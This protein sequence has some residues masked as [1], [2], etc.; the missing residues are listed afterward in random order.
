MKMN[1]LLVSAEASPYGKVGGLGDIVH[2]LANE[3]NV[4]G[5][6]AR[7]AVP[8]YRGAL[9]KVDTKEIIHT[10][11]IPLGTYS[12][13]AH[14]WRAV[15]KNQKAYLIQDDHDFY[16]GRNE[17]YGY[18]DDYERFIFFARAVLEMLISPE[19]SEKENK[20]FP[21]IIQ[22][23]DWVGG[24][25][26][27][28]FSGYQ[29]KD[30]R[31]DK[32]NFVF[33]IH[34]IRAV[35]LFG[36]RA[37]R[38][39]EQE[40]FGIF[41]EIN[42]TSERINFLGRGILLADK[43]IV[44]NPEYG[45]GNPLP[46]SAVGLEDVLGKYLE[47]N[48]IVGIRNAIDY[49]EFDPSNPLDV[50]SP[51]QENSLANRIK[52][53]IALQK[54]LG[55]EQDPD[56]PLIGMVSRLIPA[57]G[58][59][60]FPELKNHLLSF[61]NLQFVILADPGVDYFREMFDEWEQTPREK[62]GQIHPWAKIYYGYDEKLAHWIYAAS[63]IL[64]IPSKEE[65]SGIQQFIAMRYGAIP[66][67]HHT[68]V[69]KKSIVPYSDSVLRSAVPEGAGIGFAF[70]NFTSDGLL[71]T[72]KGAIDLYTNKRQDWVDIQ[73]INL[74]QD[75]SWYKPAKQFFQLYSSLE[76]GPNRSISGEKLARDKDAELL[77]T[78]LEI[79]SLPGMAKRDSRV[80]LKQAA[81]L[82]RDVVECDAVYV[83]VLGNDVHA[84][85][86]DIL[87]KDLELVSKSLARSDNGDN[88][89][90][91]DAFMSKFLNGSAISAW[92]QAPDLNISIAPSPI[93]DLDKSI[94]APANRWENGRSVLITAHSRVLGRIDVLFRNNLANPDDIWV[95]K[96]LTKIALAF[97]SRLE[98]IRIAQ[99]A[100]QMQDANE[101]LLRINS[102]PEAVQ[103]ILQQAKEFSFADSAW[104]YLHPQLDAIEPFPEVE[105]RAC[106]HIAK[107]AMETRVPRYIS[108]WTAAMGGKRDLIAF[109]S[110]MAM[111]L[112][113]AE[114]KGET[115]VIGVL[116]IAKEK[117]AGFSHDVES[118]LTKWSTQAAVALQTAYSRKEIQQQ[119]EYRDKQRVEQLRKLASSLVGGGDLGSLLKL[120]VK[121]TAEVLEAQAAS[122]YLL[123]SANLLEIRA[124]YGYHDPL[125]GQAVYEINEGI[126]GWIVAENT[127]L[128]ANTLDELHCHP[129]WKGKYTVQNQVYSREP[130]AFLGIP[131]TIV[132]PI[133]SQKQ[134]I[135]VLKLEDRKLDTP[136]EAIEFSDE[137]VR[138]GEMMANVIA[139][140]VY[141]TQVSDAQ[142]KAY[143]NNLGELS[144]A[145]A[146]GREM[147]ELVTQVVDTMARVLHAEASSLY[148]IDEVSGNLVIKAATGYQ[149]PLEEKHVT[150]MLGEGITGWIA[151][152]GKPFRAGS[153]AELM[154]HPNWKGKQDPNQDN[155]Q[156]NSY[157]GLPLKVVDRA[158][159]RDKVIGVLKVEDIVPSEKHPEAFFT[160][161]DVLL[162]TMMA[163]VIATV[164]YNTQVGDTQ[165]QIF[166]DNLGELSQAL[167]G[168]KEM[169][170]LV[171]Q[172]V[173]TMARVLHAE[174][175]SLYLIE[176]ASGKL[177]IKA[178]TGYQQPLVEKHVTYTLGEGITGWIADKGEAFRASS[179]AELTK[180][181]NW[182]GKQDPNQ[183]NRQP[184]S[185]LGLPLKVVDRATGKA[186][187][188]GVLKVEDIVPSEKHSEAF[189]TDQDVL[190]VTMMANVI[191]TVV[192]N[193]QVGDA[194]LQTFSNNL[195][196]LSQALTGGREMGELVTKVVDTMA[197]VLHAEASSLYLIDEASGMLVIQ[198]AT[199]YQK[200]LVEKHV[201]YTLGEGITG[202]IAEKGEAFRASSKAELTKH[203]NWK[204]KQDPNQDNRQPNS[205]LGL[206][207]KVVDRATKQDK[208]IG[209]LKVE[210]VVP[211]EKHPEAFFTD[212]DVLLVT[213]M[214]NVI[215]AVINNT[216][217]G[218]ARV[219]DV[220]RQIG[221]LSR[222]ENAAP[223]LLRK[224]AQT[225]NTGLLD[226][227]AIAIANCLDREPGLV[228]AEVQAL[229]EADANLAIYDR[230]VGWAKNQ[231]VRWEF[232]LFRNVLISSPASFTNWNQ[233][234]VAA[235]PW[236]R[237]RRNASQPNSF[238]TE[239]KQLVDKIATATHLE[240][241]DFG[242][243]ASES[244]FGNVL[245]TEKLFGKDVNRIPILFH[246]Q[247]TFASDDLERMLHF[248]D[249]GLERP[250]KIVIL[251]L[252]DTKLPDDH[253]RQIQNRMRNHAMDVVVVTIADLLQVLGSPSPADALRSMVLRQMTTTSPFITSGPVPDAMFFGRERELREITQYVGADRSIIVI[254]GRRIGKTSILARLYRVRLP[255][256]G[257]RAIYLDCSTI[258]SYEQFLSTPIREWRP[259]APKN[260]CR[261]MGDLLSA[262]PTDKP[263]VLL[264]DEADK[265]VPFERKSKWRLFNRLRELTNAGQMKIILS[266]ESAL[267]EAMSDDS[268]PLF[269]LFNELLLGRLELND[270][271]ELVTRPFRQLE[272]DLVDKDAIVRQI[273]NITSGHPNVVQR[274]CRR[275]INHIN[276]TRSAGI[277]QITPKDVEIIIENPDFQRDDFLSTYFASATALE[278]I[279]ILFMA[280]D[281]SICTLETV[282]QALAQQ[283]V[284]A[285]AIETDKALRRLVDLRSI[286]K[287]EPS[288]YI[289]AVDAFPRVVAGRMVSNEML[290]ILKE[291]YV[292][293]QLLE[294]Q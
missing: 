289:F 61:R 169:S 87:P 205:Y 130:R 240:I 27:A 275:L 199:G 237:I 125:L 88:N 279:I 243:D 86:S 175:S 113:I 211:S 266:G 32:T 235:E 134:V 33:A 224:F 23:Y 154:K 9:N 3:L 238:G 140:V 227:L 215:A 136:Q 92:Y 119:R 77:Q 272:I 52:N 245:D 277:R 97:G 201:T 260:T 13:Y 174:A 47:Q 49:G 79:D 37:L 137:D 58:F 34:N 200:P 194:Q 135:G 71:E 78:L 181:P 222:P 187:V 1:I 217:Q 145:L 96:A 207:L 55:F 147:G 69:L 72:L 152:K 14:I 133:S 236:L 100:D 142:L 60:I 204:G 273:Y 91:D 259:D 286:L 4:Q 186:R 67:V 51:F 126:T 219:G 85:S 82:V 150:Y 285:T 17:I 278:Q 28:W 192:Y 231:Q 38:V 294:K 290:R 153:K 267:R 120:V 19:F 163:N 218:E 115:N 254:G 2:G 170:A 191:A 255:E 94:H 99:K 89:E 129:A 132:N 155:R 250:Y 252:W 29:K 291:K 189:F 40:E 251:V 282:E 176:E 263:L 16:F 110:I 103:V 241:I 247:K 56:I 161:Q 244:W 105:T 148:L 221:I 22:G 118:V 213:M 54:E 48:R 167:A 179:K 59:E 7:I 70:E 190:L 15:D 117:P 45:P 90:P 249:R 156:P 269:N 281:S 149:K 66:L 242:V 206:P 109:R 124:A 151:D 162:V 41:K 107:A 73:R 21:D 116:I 195:G 293:E 62:T 108:D 106:L 8:C 288:G 173:D 234:M 123:N 225:D 262:P 83:W 265:L 64:M 202:W 284:M 230:I 228:D 220:L 63:D 208:V 76:K 168:G 24:I 53:K 271:D 112:M 75:F 80:M 184:N 248:A 95:D 210:D 25:I 276:E 165:L 209:V 239:V 26:P 111:P 268:S 20:W 160:D 50:N 232:S 185:Y 157:L 159:K 183:D 98:S 188:I 74:R 203:P 198:A 166:S 264:L 256:L 141:N 104:L 102:L 283:E 36:Q 122:L 144:Q 172:V 287:R 214:A 128:R 131:L 178:A 46:Q 139:T 197:R 253:I 6:D 43:V 35:R 274:L 138:L 257:F 11:D 31:F 182:K 280:K 44:D 30:Q 121:T 5:C 10:L 171:Q 12:R 39:S 258:L 292:S 18:M 177:V 270:V 84:A 261:N 193:T 81:R 57:K 143:S 246:R 101:K 146:G 196:E 65:P 93:F 114:E 164:V 158:T 212:Q 216:R 229:F 233:V 127:T 68:G 223:T 42:E 226:Q 180:H